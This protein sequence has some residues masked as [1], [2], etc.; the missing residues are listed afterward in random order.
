MKK[1]LEDNCT[2]STIN[3]PTP[4]EMLYASVGVDFLSQ[5]GNKELANRVKAMT[6][7]ELEIV[8]D[9]IPVELCLKRIQKEL[10]KAKELE[11]G[12]ANIIAR[13]GG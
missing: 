8:A 13:L 10:D 6:P 1:I 12:L 11:N 5:V 3:P 4:G 7:E 2:T 9:N